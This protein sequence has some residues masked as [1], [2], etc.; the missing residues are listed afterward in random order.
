MNFKTTDNNLTQEQEEIVNKRK[1][2]IQKIKEYNIAVNSGQAAEING[3]KAARDELYKL[4]DAYKTAHNI[5]SNGGA[6]K[7]GQAYG[8]SQLQNFT[9]RYNSLLGG[10]SDVGLNEQSTAVVNLSNAYK[11]LQV[12]QSA[13]VA[14]E[15]KTTAEYAEKIEAFKAAQLAC[16]NYAKEL[17]SVITTSK[18]LQ[19]EGIGDPY[20]LVNGEFD[21]NDAVYASIACVNASIPV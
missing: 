6:I 14:G 5:A 20:S 13:F 1:E 10:A 17:N 4:I 15:D 3:I 21:L 12:A 11:Q 9:A 16:N 2:L 18:K 7:K 8:T 19:S